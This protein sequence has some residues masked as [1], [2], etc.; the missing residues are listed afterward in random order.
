MLD[1]NNHPIPPDKQ[2]SLSF[3]FFIEEEEYDEPPLCKAG[4]DVVLQ[5][6]VDW[7]LLDGRESSDDH[8]IVQ[9]EWTLLQGDSAVEM[10]VLRTGDI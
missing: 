4:Q 2:L 7:V 6:P 1:I 10:K 8:G 3:F 9:Y 5:S